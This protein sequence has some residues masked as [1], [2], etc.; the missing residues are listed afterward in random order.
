MTDGYIETYNLINWTIIFII[1]VVG[2]GLAVLLWFKHKKNLLQVH[3]ERL[4]DFVMLQVFVPR[5]FTG[6]K[7]DNQPPKD[8]REIISVAEQLFSSCSNLSQK[9]WKSIIYG[10]SAV[11]FEIIAKAQE[12][13]FYI[14]VPRSFQT[15]FEKQILG[16]YPTAQVEETQDFKIFREDLRPALGA[17]KQERRF[18]L[19]IKTYKYLESDPL[20]NIANALSKLGENTRADIQILVR[21][22]YNQNWRWATEKASRSISEGKSVSFGKRS[23]P[24][25]LVQGIISL[26]NFGS[27]HATTKGGPSTS[28]SDQ[29]AR[30][31]PLQ[32]EQMKT[33][34]EKAGKT[35]LEAQIRILVLS[36]SKEESE[37]H[38]QNIFGSFAQFGSP[39]RN[40]FRLSKINDKGLNQFLS[41]FI[42]RNFWGKGRLI[43]NLEE[44]ATIYHFPN[45]NVETPSIQWLLAKRSPAPAN[46]PKEGIV[47]GEN[48]FRGEKQVVR[49]KD[50]DRRRHLYVI[51]MT[52]TGKSTLFENMILQDIRRGAGVC[53]IDPH[54][55][56]AEAILGKIPRSRAHEVI[57]FDPGNI[58]TPF[59]LNLLEWKTPE[60]K[61]FLVQEAIQIF[62][63]LFD[64]THMGIVGPQFEH[65]MRNAALTVMEAPGGGT[66]IE[67]PRLFVDDA[68]REEKI[69]TVEN[70]VVKTFWT[71]QLAKTADFH[72]SEMYNYFISKFGRFM[73]N[74]MMRNIIGQ[75]KS[76]FDFKQ[77]MD[78]GKIL[79]VNLSK[80][81]VGEINSNLLGMILVAKLYTAAMGRFET[82]EHERR[83][84]YLYVDEFQNIATDTFSSILSEA[85]KYHLNLSLTNQY[86]AQLDEPIR[87]AIIGNVGTLISFRIGVPDAEFMA[88][89]FEPVFSQTDLINIEKFN[90]YIKMLI[91][92]TPTRAFSLHTLKAP[93]AYDS[94]IGREIKQSSSQKNGLPR[95]QVEN[96]LQAR[97]KISGVN[98]QFALGAPPREA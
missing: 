66:L 61:D 53:F 95:A 43:V 69:K 67:I 80:G 39:E 78:G 97:A 32:E 51:G 9:G 42:L 31:T 44:L 29:L 17:L 72:K 82:P 96:E 23:W 62:Y 84:F 33:L 12:I 85:R 15:F 6:E 75:T 7:K 87:D 21:P 49:L 98:E 68:F 63:K 40:A 89:E 91:D 59:G 92:N 35:G 76:S 3:S 93:A 1:F 52:G 28:A 22:L 34:S 45:Q 19:P 90:A 11:S 86:I 38:L 30:L 74:E 46:L 71:Q 37:R 16:F 2:G 10:Q 47:L 8:F 70:P 50:E 57:Y 58:E 41:H 94:N 73:T 4:S 56:T 65:W 81:K 25:K 55:E 5:D 36:P 20:G 64:P 48:I 83:D 24:M 18:I 14:G 60:Q 54:G 13:G 88:K 79:I 26:F 27:S 77:V